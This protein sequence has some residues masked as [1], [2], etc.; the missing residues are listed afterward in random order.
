MLGL[1]RL[2]QHRIAHAVV[3]LDEAFGVL[4]EDASRAGNHADLLADEL[5]VDRVVPAAEAHVAVLSDL[6]LVILLARPRQLRQLP[7]RRG[8]PL[9][10]PL[11]RALRGLLP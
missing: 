3:G 6:A 4:N 10:E 8:L 11:D 7:Q 9:N 5:G 2:R 1:G